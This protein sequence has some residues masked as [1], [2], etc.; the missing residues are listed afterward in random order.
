MIKRTKQ[1]MILKKY[2]FLLNVKVIEKKIKLTM[3]KFMNQI[4]DFD[5]ILRSEHDYIH[6]YA[7][8]ENSTIVDFFF[9]FFSMFTS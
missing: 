7:E 2:N 4:D 9:L 6:E 5:N 1:I 3:K 8:F